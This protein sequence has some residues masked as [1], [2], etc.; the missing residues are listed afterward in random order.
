MHSSS[1]SMCK[2][3]QLATLISDEHPQVNDTETKHN[4]DGDIQEPTA[5]N[6][7]ENCDLEDN[8]ERDG[9]M[10]VDEANKDTAKDDHARSS[11]LA[12][13]TKALDKNKD[14]FLYAVYG[15]STS[16]TNFIKCGCSAGITSK[17][18]SRCKGYYPGQ[19]KLIR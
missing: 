18:K 1:S 4:R 13:L 3:H 17:F 5:T 6:A 12:R 16:G 7:D 19:Q 14:P 2:V 8:G 10:E 9:E 11:S 15:T